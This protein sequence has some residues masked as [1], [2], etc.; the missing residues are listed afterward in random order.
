M[1]L[2]LGNQESS[3]NFKDNWYPYR[4]DSTFLYY[5][6]LNLPGLHALI[7]LDSVEEI[8]FGDELTLDEIVWRGPQPTMAD[9]SAKVGILDTRPL[10]K[11]KAYLSQREVHYLPAYRPEH[12][13]FLTSLLDRSYT[14]VD[15][16]YSVSFIKVVAAQ[17]AVKS[18]EEL[19]SY[20][21]SKALM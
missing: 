16:E 2:F 21:V 7:D 9:M 12:I 17:R 20:L 18:P 5:F 1:L 8:I 10:E 4:Q 13:L 11:M 3:I 14:E 6:G 19:L 15:L